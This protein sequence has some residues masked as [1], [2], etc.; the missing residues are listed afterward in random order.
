MQPRL[1][2]LG[3]NLIVVSLIVGLIGWFSREYYILGIAAS[4]SLFGIVSLTIG[5]GHREP[6]MEFVTRYT[7]AL[8]NTVLTLLDHLGINPANLYAIP[9]G[10]NVY[11]VAT[12]MDNP[13]KNPEPF[14]RID[15]DSPYLGIE[16]PPPKDYIPETIPL[17]EISSYIKELI[18]SRYAIAGNVSA[19]VEDN[20][21]TILLENIDPQLLDFIKKPLS[22]VTVFILVSTARV[23]NKSLA[24]RN[25]VIEDNSLT[26]TLEVLRE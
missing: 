22:P 2:V 18:A 4:I 3:V 6:S 11:L 25:E 7:E 12:S 23:L 20:T 24:L 14:I 8:R 5:L 17:N 21:I 10:R 1:I 9:K 16:I 19:H 15:K 26:I 13:P